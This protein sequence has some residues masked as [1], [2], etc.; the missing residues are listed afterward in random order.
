MMIEAA[1]AAP[2]IVPA[3]STPQMNQRIVF[4]TKRALTGSSPFRHD[5]W[6]WRVPSDDAQHLAAFPERIQDGIQ[7]LFGVAGRVAR[8]DQGLP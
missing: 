8:P 4:L 5:L 6:A 1:S 2:A 3:K 7:L